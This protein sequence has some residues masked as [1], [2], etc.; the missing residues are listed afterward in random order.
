MQFN[1]EPTT[2][3]QAIQR[4][5]VTYRRKQSYF[6]RKVMQH[7]A[8][9]RRH[10]QPKDIAPPVEIVQPVKPPPAVSTGERP[11]KIVIPQRWEITI[12]RIVARY[13]KVGVHE[14]IADMRYKKYVNPRHI[15]MWIARVMS[16]EKRSYP[17]ISKAMGNRD[18]TTILHARLRIDRMRVDPVFAEQVQFLMDECRKALFHD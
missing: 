10:D 14:I 13:Y 4:A 15:C 1:D 5:A 16:N 18:H 8:V 12:M 11:K 7:E 17:L 3:V 9:E 6:E 2:G